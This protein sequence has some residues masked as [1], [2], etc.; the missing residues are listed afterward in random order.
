LRISEGR[1]CLDI[2]EREGAQGSSYDIKVSLVYSGVCVDEIRQLSQILERS[3][4]V[5]EGGINK[6]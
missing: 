5:K 3:G 4:L 6:N 2:V 1:A